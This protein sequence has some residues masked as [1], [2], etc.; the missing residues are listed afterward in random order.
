[1]TL[2]FKFHGCQLQVLP[3]EIA[4]VQRQNIDELYDELEKELAATDGGGGDTTTLLIE[5]QT[6]NNREG[7]HDSTDDGIQGQEDDGDHDSVEEAKV[8]VDAAGASVEDLLRFLQFDVVQSPSDHHYLR[9]M[10]QVRAVNFV[11][12][13]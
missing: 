4:V 10:E 1:L 8:A 13:L 6:D 11:Y 9:D 12:F 2:S 7:D 5:R 3:H